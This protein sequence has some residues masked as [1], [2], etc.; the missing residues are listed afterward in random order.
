MI[1]RIVL[2]LDGTEDTSGSLVPA[3]V[4]ANWFDARLQIV[5]PDQRAR[6]R[7]DTLAAGLGIPVDSVV[8]LEDGDFTERL[9]AYVRDD[10][11]SVCVHAA[12]EDGFRLADLSAQATF[13]VGDGQSNRLSSGPLLVA[14][15]GHD[16]DLDALAVAATW[17]QVLDLQIR[18]VVEAGVVSSDRVADAQQHL[19]KIGIDSGIDWLDGAAIEH[20]LPIAMSRSA[21]AVVV[22]ANRLGAREL[23]AAATVGGVSVVVAPTTDLGAELPAPERSDG[24]HRSEQS[25]FDGDD[26]LSRPECRELLASV[27]IGR[28]GYVDDGWPVIVPVNYTI[29]SGDVFVRSMPG[30]KL[31]AARRGDVVCLEADSFDHESKSGWSVVV[32][33]PLE[34]VSDPQTLRVAWSQEL[35]PWIDSASWQWL[36]LRSL[37]MTGRRVAPG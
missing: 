9:A 22:P 17:A 4:L 21:T 27:S 3:I 36:R 14:I 20:V 31:E 19:S 33:G 11:T 16:A 10:D 25:R 1:Q 2:P 30:A 12:N 6:P 32:H 35:A 8:A 13:L 37:S 24:N 28:L 29:D 7:L 26:A 23:I 18:L 15:D 34:V 5:T